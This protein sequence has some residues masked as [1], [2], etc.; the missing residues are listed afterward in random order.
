MD[1]ARFARNMEAA[2][3]QIWRRHCA[4]G[5]SVAAGAGP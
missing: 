1:G 4:A 2:Y 3:Q 5:N